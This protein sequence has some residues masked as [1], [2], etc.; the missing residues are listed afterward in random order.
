[1]TNADAN[2]NDQ[3]NV[4]VET[5]STSHPET[6]LAPV[7]IT[8]SPTL[9]GAPTSANLTAPQVS[10]NGARKVA[11]EAPD[12][13]ATGPGSG[14][15]VDGEEVV[16][17]GTYSLRNF[18]GRI[19]LRAVLTIG[20]LASAVYTWDSKDHRYWLPVTLVFAVVVV[21]LWVSLLYRIAQARWG[22][23]YH[24]STRR[25]S[26]ATGLMRRRIDQME[27]LRVQDVFTRQTLLDRWLSLGTVVVVPSEKELPTFY[28]AGVDDPN[29]VLDLVWHYAR[30]ERD[31]HSTNVHAV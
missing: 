12:D 4:P 17:E 20:L 6:L 25:L 15:G 24:L 13:V 14:V 7:Q 30:A 26:V 31:R 23:K 10:A 18:L 19:I 16:W 28:L 8:S 29:A 3:T 2:A 9:D 22:H 27:L 1:M 11:S 5:T 21:A